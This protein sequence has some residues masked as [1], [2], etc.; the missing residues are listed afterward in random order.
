MRK[1]LL[2]AMLLAPLGWSQVGRSN[3]PFV[4]IG[5]LANI[6]STCRV[7]TMAFITNVAAGTNIRLCT[8]SNTWTS[9]V[10]GATTVTYLSDAGTPVATSHTTCGAGATVFL[11]TTNQ[12]FW[13]CS[14]TNIWKKLLSTLNTG[15]FV[16]TAQAGA[17]PA[18]PAAGFVSCYGDSTSKT[19]SCVDDTGAVT[20]FLSSATVASLKVRACATFTF[21]GQGSVITNNTVSPTGEVLTALTVAGYNMYVDTGTIT[22]DVLKATNSNGTPSFATITSSQTPAIASGTNKR[23]TTVN[24]WTSPSVNDLLQA[25]VTAV[26]AAT[27]ASLVVECTQ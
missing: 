12:D 1:F 19:W 16:L 24:L 5:I 7:G 14:A 20:S 15:T 25:K 22:I 21:D 26:S 11:D 9:E 17:T 3:P 8:S 13:F 18:T 6:P 10:Q 4:Y 2:L 27:K 23:S